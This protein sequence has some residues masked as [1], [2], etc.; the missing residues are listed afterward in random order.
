MARSGAAF[1]PT[2]GQAAGLTLAE[3]R[4]P[5]S[6]P[7]KLPGLCGEAGVGSVLAGLA[8]GTESMGTNTC[9]FTRCASDLRLWAMGSPG[10]EWGARRVRRQQPGVG[11]SPVCSAAGK[12]G[13]QRGLGRGLGAGRTGGRPR[14]S[15]PACL[16]LSPLFPHCVALISPELCIPAY[17]RPCVC[18]CHLAVF[19]PQPRKPRATWRCRWRRM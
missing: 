19:R 10:T 17:L 12:S 18:P 9:V 2:K 1:S 13:W 15:L 11:V 6:P 7:E 5:S 4:A 14:R 16:L 8:L 3:S